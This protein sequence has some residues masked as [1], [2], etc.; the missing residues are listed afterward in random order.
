MISVLL[1]AA[2]AASPTISLEHT[3]PLREGLQEIARKGG[4]NL[5]ASGRLRALAERVRELEHRC[6]AV[7]GKPQ[8]EKT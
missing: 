4:L 6:E 8:E 5:V 7:A 2:L 3:G 1:A